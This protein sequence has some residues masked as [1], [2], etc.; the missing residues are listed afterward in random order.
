MKF[1]APLRRTLGLL[2]V[3]VCLAGGLRAQEA[4]VAETAERLDEAKLL[5][6]QAALPS[7]RGGNP[8]ILRESTWSGE[9]ESGKARL[10]QVQLFKRNDYRFW[11]AVPDRRVAVSL[12]LYNGEGEL[13]QTTPDPQETPNVAGLEVVPEETGIY[14]LRIA[15]QGAVQDR[16]RWSVIYA[17]R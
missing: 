10:I 11:F 12:A 6:Q 3:F 2:A 4:V 15:L 13:V 14:F 1:E 7:L 16:Q 9:I 5:A 17:W 8:F